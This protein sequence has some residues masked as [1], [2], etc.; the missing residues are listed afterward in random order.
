M[1]KSLLLG[2]EAVAQGSIDAGI[3]GIY[4]YPG[5]PATEIMEYI[6]SSS[7]ANER[8]ISCIWSSNE[9]TAM[10]TALGM[11]YAGKR[12]MVA[13]KHVGLNVA[14]DA[15]INSAITGVNGGLVIVAADD[16]SMHSSQNEQDSRFYGKFAM[17]PV[18]EPRN[19][20]EAYDVVFDAFDLSEKYSVPVLIRITTRLAHS[21]S[22]VCRNQQL[23]E[24]KFNLPDDSKRF[25]LM[26]LIARRRF[27]ILL[28]NQEKFQFDNRI[29][30][31]NFFKDAPERK[32]GIIACGIAVNYLLE[33]FNEVELQYPLLSIG[34][35]PFS[36]DII[37]DLVYRCEEILVL[38]EGYPL[39]E[40]LLRGIIDGGRK[41]Y[42][43]MDGSIPRDGE[44]N[45]DIIASALGINVRKGPPVPEIVKMRPPSFCNGCGHADMFRAIID[46]MKPFGVR[47]VFSDIGCYTLAALPPY[48]FINTCVEMGASITMAVG[49][50]DAGFFPSVAVI[51]DSTF[52]HSGMTGLLDAVVRNSP[53]TVIIADNHATGMTG[54]QKSSGTGRLEDICR[55]LGV[56]PEHVRTIIPLCKY[57]DENVKI[58]REEFEYKSPS[59][60]IATR[61]CI[62][63]V[64]RK[65][66]E[67]KK[68]KTE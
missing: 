8:K 63:V 26:P 34:A 19:Q 23:P 45:P 53:V 27:R 20:Q 61:E 29:T 33:N 5:T 14:S 66:K 40:E 67:E 21:R 16:P 51:G 17:T 6:Q 13:M 48:N 55:G 32:L 50:A 9:K 10:E 49:A 60:I 11:S 12:A 35:Y 65:R 30:R 42:G 59:V 28:E 37:K 4:S 1:D 44:L 54:G 31:Y 24:K 36:K 2:D 39:V 22:A 3:S 58:M 15:F 62:Q 43:K 25:V 56:A 64:A 57:H 47:G 41:I 18:Y 38:E 7:V 68:A 46:A 52:T